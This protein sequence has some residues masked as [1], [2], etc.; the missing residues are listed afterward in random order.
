MPAARTATGLQELRQVG[1]VKGAATPGATKIEV[2]PPRRPYDGDQQENE[3]GH[4]HDGQDGV[5]NRADALP[6]LVQHTHAETPA[7]QKQEGE[8]AQQDRPFLRLSPLV[9]IYWRLLQ[10]LEPS[11]FPV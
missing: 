5:P 3:K 6:A 4:E 11:R 7:N 9:W 10:S 8:E 2:S 1:V